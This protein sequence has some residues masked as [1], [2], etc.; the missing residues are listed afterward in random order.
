MKKSISRSF[1][2]LTFD[3]SYKQEEADATAARIEARIGA[4][5]IAV[6]Q[7]YKLTDHRM[8]DHDVEA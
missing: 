7:G 4:S 8:E 6:K 1:H 2:I 3:P 5:V